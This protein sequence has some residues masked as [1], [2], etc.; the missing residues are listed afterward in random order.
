M[1][2]FVRITSSLSLLKDE[3]VLLFQSKKEMKTMKLEPQLTSLLYEMVMLKNE[4]ISK[5]DLIEAVWNGNGYVGKEALRKNI[6]K[7]RSLIAKVDLLDEL[8]IITIPKKGYKLE[9]A[10]TQSKPKIH[11]VFKIISYAAASII[12]ILFI[13]NFSEGENVDYKKYADSDYKKVE[14]EEEE[15]ILLDP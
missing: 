13:L 9:I 2:S 7:L 3:N 1:K 12:L 10:N 15:I 5:E 14:I 11:K 8:S 4:V 6:Y